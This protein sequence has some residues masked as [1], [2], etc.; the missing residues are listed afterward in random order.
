MPFVGPGLRDLL[1]ALDFAIGR[2][3]PGR[4]EYGGAV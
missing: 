2:S 1:G 4:G 3:Y